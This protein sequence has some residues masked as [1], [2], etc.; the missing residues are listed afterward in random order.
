MSGTLFSPHSLISGLYN[1]DL[2]VPN[3]TGQLKYH[4]RAAL[5]VSNLNTFALLRLLPGLHVT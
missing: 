2:L 4:L 3:I 1:L 5:M